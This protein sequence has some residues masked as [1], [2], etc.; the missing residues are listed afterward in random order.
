MYKAK[1]WDFLYLSAPDCVAQLNQMGRLARVVTFILHLGSFTVAEVE[2][3]P[4][5]QDGHS[6]QAAPVNQTD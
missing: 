3:D 4:I 5:R 6:C 1:I 2:F